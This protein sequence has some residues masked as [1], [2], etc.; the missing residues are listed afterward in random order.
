MGDLILNSLEIQNF[1]GFQDLKIDR[2]GRVNLIVGKNNIGKSSL[3]DALLLY[4]H[5]GSPNDIW[6]ILNARDESRN[7]SNRLS[8]NRVSNEDLLSSLKYLFYGRKEIQEHLDAILIGPMDSKEETISINLG[9]YVSQ[10]DEDG[11]SKLQLLQ[12]EELG[13]VDNP[14]PRFAIQMG[15]QP[16]I[17]YPLRADSSHIFRLEAEGINCI[18]VSTRGLDDDRG[19]DINLVG[20]WDRVALRPLENEVL[21]S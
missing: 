21:N 8:R 11:F 14:I 2:L 13:L 19:K 16:K 4:A 18:Y 3:L 9:W 10:S 1:R 5:R 15:D 17:S 12:P 20:L 7:S 6:D